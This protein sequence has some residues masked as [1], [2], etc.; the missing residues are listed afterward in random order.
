MTLRD[1]EPAKSIVRLRIGGTPPRDRCSDARLD[2]LETS[3][4][5]DQ[6]LIETPTLTLPL[7]GGV[8]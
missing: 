1:V 3:K 5:M 6:G 4:H 2:Q 8:N 7:R